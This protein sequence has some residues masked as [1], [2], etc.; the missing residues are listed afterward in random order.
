MTESGRRK[1]YSSFL[2]Q[3]GPRMGDSERLSIVIG[4]GHGCSEYFDA[5]RR[6]ADFVGADT[7]FNIG[8]LGGKRGLYF[9]ELFSDLEGYCVPGNHDKGGMLEELEESFQN[10]SVLDNEKI[11]W[12]K[13]EVVAMG[14]PWHCWTNG[15]YRKQLEN[16]LEESSHATLLSHYGPKG[17]S[18][19]F[20]R[21]FIKVVKGNPP[22]H[23]VHAHKHPYSIRKTYL[24]LGK[25]EWDDI[26]APPNGSKWGLN[27]AGRIVVM[28]SDPFSAPSYFP[29]QTLEEGVILGEGPRESSPWN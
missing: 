20:G 28:A 11:V 7:V 21:G 5:A 13:R 22:L 18:S 25:M 17:E 29:R 24:K 16:L 27:A 26:Y 19:I 10:F 3:E 12:G 2:G 9:F 23:I 6:V 8:D 15:K 4:D 1:S 14:L